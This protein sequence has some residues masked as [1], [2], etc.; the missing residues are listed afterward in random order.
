MEWVWREEIGI[1]VL[2]LLFQQAWIQRQIVWFGSSSE[3]TG[4]CP[5]P[6][7]HIFIWNDVRWNVQGFT[8]KRPS[9]VS[10]CFSKLK[11]NHCCYS[12][13]AR[14]HKGGN[15]VKKLVRFYLHSSTYDRLK[16]SS[17]YFYC[18]FY[19][20]IL[21]LEKRVKFT[22]W[23][24]FHILGFIITIYWSSVDVCVFYEAQNSVFFL[25]THAVLTADPV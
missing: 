20:S 12:R 11:K 7:K 8:E 10:S 24:K 19:L 3:V 25:S 21:I 23:S 5:R 13:I 16:R 2:F 1:F 9:T 15:P 4:P 14:N 6:T 22:H 17:F 18:R